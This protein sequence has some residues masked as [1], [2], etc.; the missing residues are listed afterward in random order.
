MQVDGYEKVLEREP[1]N[2]TALEG[3]AQIH[4]QTSNVEEAIPVLEKMVEYY[5]ER[6]EYA[7]I[8]DIVKQQQASQQSQ[9]ETPQPETS[10]PESQ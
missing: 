6:Q 9:P 10:P 4:L 3:L 2:L 5:P 7:G 8:L 1:Q